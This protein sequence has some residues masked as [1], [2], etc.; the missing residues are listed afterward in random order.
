MQDNV[1]DAYIENQEWC[2]DPT[3]VPTTV[4]EKARQV[5]M[6]GIMTELMR[7]QTWNREQRRAFV[8]AMGGFK[9][10]RGQRW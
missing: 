9:K 1:K 4:V 5:G 6:S 8:R 10:K 7:S 3:T 2:I